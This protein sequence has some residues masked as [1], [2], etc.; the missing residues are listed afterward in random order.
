LP[1][2]DYPWR[3]GLDPAPKIK[4]LNAWMAAYC[5][6]QKF[7]YLDYYA[8]MVGEDGG[9]KEGISLDGVHPNAAGYAIMEPLAEAG[10]AKA[11]KN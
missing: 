2:A 9:M 10:L 7:V 5:A 8:A 3:K 1:A 6:A 4:E 11:R